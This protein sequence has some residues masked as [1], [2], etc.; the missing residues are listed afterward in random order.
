MKVI[1]DNESIENETYENKWIDV[2]S[3]LNKSHHTIQS[4]I[5]IQSPISGRKKN[6][7]F[8]NEI[9]DQQAGQEKFNVDIKAELEQK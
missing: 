3:S 7:S 8:N 4:V 1:G 9:E 6:K 2:Q 5:S